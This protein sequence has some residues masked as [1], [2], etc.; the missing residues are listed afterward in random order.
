MVSV[1]KQARAAARC[2]ARADTGTKNRALVTMAEALTRT[3]KGLLGAN[4]RDLEAAKQ[5]NLDPALIDRLTLSAR[6][7]EEMASSTARPGYKSGKC[8]CRWA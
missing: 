2:I 3:T 5:K 7:I 4:A 6:T 8:A 1:G